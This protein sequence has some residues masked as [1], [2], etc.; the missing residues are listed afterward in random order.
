MA[1]RKKLNLGYSDFKNI[2]K[3]DSYF[4]DKSLFIKE[5][6]D[7]EKNVL[8][9]PRPRRFGK[10]LN[11]SMLRYFFDKNEPENEKLFTG[12]KIWQTGEDIKKHCCKYPVIFLSFKD[13]K[14]NNWEDCYELIINEIVNLYSEHDY[15]LEKSILKNYEKDEYFK[16]LKKTAKNADY[17]NSL[18]Q[19]TKYLQRFHNT[20]VIVLIDEYDT[21]IQS[22]HK[23]FYEEVVSFMRNLL[24]GA[25][26][27]NTYLHK[28]VIT[29]ILRVSKESIFSGLNNLSV[30]SIL[31]DEFA[32]KFGFTEPEVKEIIKDFKV[33]TKYSEIKKWYNGY[34]FG[35]ISK[36]YNPW[37][38]LNFVV[39]KNEKFKPFWTNTSANELIKDEIKKKSADNIREEILK[40]I[41]G[42]TIVKDIEENFVFPDLDKRKSLL[43]TLLTYSGYLT[44]NREISLGEYELL[45]PNHELKIIFKKT[46]VE[47]LEADIKIIKSLLQDSVNNLIN[48]EIAKF[49]EG[50]KEIMGDTFSYYDTAKNNEYVYHSYILGLLAIIGDDYLVKSNKESGEGRYDIMLIPHDKSKNGVV[51]EIK[52]IEKQKE[53]EKDEDFVKRINGQIKKAAKQIDRNKYYKELIVNKIRPENIIKV[54]VVFAGKEPYIIQ[55]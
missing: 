9:F 10:T 26:K 40:L 48:N 42:N 6:I 43:W 31:H 45:I 36:I 55:I 21:P 23:K 28:G 17:Q 54:P 12:L 16:I 30:N 4:V 46:I 51:I 20:N 39:S 32:D 19:L 24:S 15:I 14:A 41:N 2:I 8:L 47:W 7:A 44:T 27:D 13:A 29:G 5:V 1:D 34:K 18:K 49:E 37:S 52:Q 33:K 25:F 22:G 38:I 50:F 3:S 11:L 53:N 35:E